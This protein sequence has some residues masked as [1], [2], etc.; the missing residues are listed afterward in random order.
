[1]GKEVTEYKYDLFLSYSSK[2]VGWAE[3]LQ[4]ALLQRGIE[5]YRDK[6][7]LTAGD[8]WQPQLQEAIRKSRHLIV[9]WSTP[10]RE[11]D[12]V[13]QERMYF[14]A[15]LKGSKEPRRIVFVNLEAVNK[16]QAS[17]EQ[18]DDI[19][20]AGLYP[21][22]AASLDSNPKVRK[23]VLDR[24]EDAVKEQDS[25]PI[26]K[27]LMVS[28]LDTL[29]NTPLNARAGLAPPFGETL[30]E[31]EIRQDDTDAYKTE[32]AKYYDNERSAWKPFGLDQPIDT[33]LDDLRNKVQETANAPRFRWRDVGEEFWSDNAEDFEL[34]L[35]NISQHL[36][37]IVIDPISLYD[38]EVMNRLPQLRSFLKPELC[39]TAVLAP[40][41]I[42]TKNSHIRRVLRGAALDIFRQYSEPAFNGS[43]LHP[44][45][46]CAH[47]PIDVRRVLCSSLDQKVLESKK[48]S[49]PVFLTH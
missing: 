3:W 10:A 7:R 28:T 32:L 40:Y 36:A 44:L 33:I 49:T 13:Y 48:Q 29:R 11:S 24:L 35:R 8:E 19:R 12:W 2:D 21:N 31:L 5:A 6:D 37:L 1:V 41:S 39:A 20:K 46:M 25:V 14:E 23:R 22:G 42:P 16:A 9:L 47:D 30:K 43:T 17:V 15:D 4:T 18:I 26:Y 38:P 27:V 34:S 45:N